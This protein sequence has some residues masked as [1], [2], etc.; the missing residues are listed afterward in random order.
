MGEK[1]ILQGLIVRDPDV[2][3]KTTLLTLQVEKV[4]EQSAEGT[5]LVVADRFAD[6]S[7][8]DYVSA[9]GKLEKPKP[10]ETNSGRN[11]LSETNSIL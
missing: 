11:A 8:G 4:N 1:V 6:V 2:R 9:I 3:E 10:F 7:Y 5:V